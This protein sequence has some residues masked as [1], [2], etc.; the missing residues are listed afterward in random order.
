V[1]AAGDTIAYEVATPAPDPGGVPVVL[2]HGSGGNR[3][4]WWRVVPLLAAGRRVVSVDVRGSG[5]STDDAALLGP[6][7]VCADLEAIRQALEIERWHVVGHSLGGWPAL[8]YAAEHPHR[9]ASAVAVSSIGGSVTEEVGRWL[10]DF[11]AANASW[12]AADEVGHSASISDAFAD[13][14]PASV[15][16]YQVL[17]D[18]NPPQRRGVPAERVMEMALDPEARAR[19]ES[20]R[21]LFLTGSEDP[22]APPAV[23]RA[24]AAGITGAA[25]DEMAGAGHVCFWEQPQEFVRRL[26]EWIAT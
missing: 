18:L 10:S 25:I 17:R 15:Y 2:V 6:H 12:A 19:L 20:V 7:Q 1:E 11:A 3:A 23:V 22:Y 8:R 26:E 24:A 21:V 16:L 9:T 14:D 4:T 5:R 13:S